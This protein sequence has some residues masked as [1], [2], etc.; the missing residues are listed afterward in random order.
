MVLMTLGRGA[1]STVDILDFGGK[2]RDSCRGGGLE[3]RM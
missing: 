1:L 3:D 2:R